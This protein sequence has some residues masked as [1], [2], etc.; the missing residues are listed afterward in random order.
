VQA[1][2][3]QGRLDF[4]VGVWAVHGVVLVVL[5]ALFAQRMS[6]LRLRLRS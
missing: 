4:S 5:V 6:L 1:R 3:S 2:V